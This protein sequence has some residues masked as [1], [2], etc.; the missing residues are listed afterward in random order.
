M[1]KNFLLIILVAVSLSEQKNLDEAELFAI[2]NKNDFDYL[3]FRQ[4][5]PQSSCLFPGINKCVIKKQVS[6]WCVH[7]LW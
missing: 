3:I 1:I 4:I 7:G 5:W 2:N 6:N